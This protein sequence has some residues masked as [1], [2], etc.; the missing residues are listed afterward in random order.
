MFALCFLHFPE[1]CKSVIPTNL[2]HVTMTHYKNGLFPPRSFNHLLSL[3]RVGRFSENQ[4]A[5][6]PEKFST[7]KRWWTG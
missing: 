7:Q 4:E 3:G 6:L 5:W 1:C 2:S